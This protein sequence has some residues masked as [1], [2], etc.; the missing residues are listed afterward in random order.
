MKLMVQVFGHV[1][2]A[3]ESINSSSFVSFDQNWTEQV[4]QLITHNYNHILGYLTPNVIPP[5][6]PTDI[7]KSHFN[8]VLYA[9]KLRERRNSNAGKRF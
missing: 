3:Y 4:G 6:P 8:W 2:I 1:A 9:R 5:T 7:I